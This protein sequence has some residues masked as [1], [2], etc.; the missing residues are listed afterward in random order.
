MSTDS[1]WSRERLGICQKWTFLEAA[2]EICGWKRGG[3]SRHK[4]T[5]WWSN[6]VG[7]AVKEKRKAWKQWKS[8]GTKEE[9]LKAKKADK[10]A[11]SFAKKKIHRQNSLPL[12]TIT[13]IKIAFLKWLK[14]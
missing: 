4:E 8:G 7:N 10:T 5:W 2:N 3:C 1:C 13:V 11:V 9:Y 14:N 6:D 12:L